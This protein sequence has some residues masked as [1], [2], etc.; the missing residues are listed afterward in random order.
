MLHEKI[1]LK[2]DDA[3]LK[4]Y[5]LDDGEFE[6]KGKLHPAM[7]VCPGGGYAYCSSNEGEPVALFYARHG[8]HAF[9]LNYDCGI[10]HPYPTQILQ[11]MEAF[12][13]V[14]EHREEFRISTISVVG[15]SA[16]G[17]LALT[18]GIRYNEE[19]LV[20]RF[21]KEKGYFRPDHVVLGYPAITLH[22][23]HPKGMIPKE[24]LELMEKGLIPDFRGPTIREILLGK[25]DPSEEELESLNLLN[26][27]HEGMPPVF[28]FG[29]I[30]DSVIPPSDLTGLSSRLIEL[31]VPVELHLLANGD[32]GVSICD[33]TVKCEEVERLNMH[34]WPELSLAFLEQN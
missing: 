20:S 4:T 11:L 16:G 22:P 1:M 30:K 31:K 26:Y 24:T 28:V 33:K 15:F 3:Y 18:L 5:V 27:L 34:K 7:I 10:G 23:M 9:V 13:Y 29:S 25:E 8:Y 19:S 12:K 21:G 14:K 17:N 2:G 6:G 32:H